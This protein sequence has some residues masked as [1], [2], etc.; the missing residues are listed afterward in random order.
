MKIFFLMLIITNILSSQEPPPADGV[1]PTCINELPSGCENI[2]LS[3]C[4]FELSQV[5]NDCKSKLPPDCSDKPLSECTNLPKEC[6]SSSNEI[7]VVTE[8]PPP[9]TETPTSLDTLELTEDGTP[10]QTPHDCV[11][12]IP[13]GCENIPLL[14]CLL[15]LTPV[16]E[17]CKV[18]MPP[19]CQDKPLTECYNPPPQCK[20]PPPSNG[21]Q[22]T[23][24]KPD[25]C[26]NESA[27]IYHPETLE[28]NVG[29]EKTTLDIPREDGGSSG[30]EIDSDGRTTIGVKPPAGKPPLTVNAPPCAQVEMKEDG[31]F[32][33]QFSTDDGVRTELNATASGDF[34]LKLKPPSGKNVEL[35]APTGSNLEVRDDGSFN[36]AFSL[37]SGLESELNISKSG[38]FEFKLKPPA[39]KPPVK[40]K[41]PAGSNMEMREDGSFK[42]YIAHENGI[43]HELDGDSDGYFD[44][45]FK[46]PKK[47]GFNFKM[48]PGSDIEIKD[49][50][51]IKEVLSKESK[52]VEFDANEDGEFEVKLELQDKDKNKTREF[53]GIDGSEVAMGEEANVTSF[54]YDYNNSLV[55]SMESDVNGTLIATISKLVP[56]KLRGSFGVVEYVQEEMVSYEMGLTYLDGGLWV[57]TYDNSNYR[58]ATTAIEASIDA[59]YTTSSNFSIEIDENLTIEFIPL[60]LSSFREITYLNKS[61]EIELLSGKCSIKIEK[62]GENFELNNLEYL[63]V[64]SN[65]IYIK[66]NLDTKESSD[67]TLNSGW[68]LISIPISALINLDTIDSEKVWSYS[69]KWIE[70]PTFIEYKSGYWVYLDSNKTINFEGF[71]YERDF[72]NLE[73]SS[74]QLI[75]S[76]VDLTNFD[77]DM[78]IYIFRD[79]KWIKNPKIIYRGEGFWIKK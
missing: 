61:K 77:K 11:H 72:S 44:F 60:E 28:A 29:E 21:T 10:I 53:V 25:E 59:N 74:W 40:L 48:P 78:T 33:Q 62:S 57:D 58:E 41:A 37:D 79:K 9:E 76:G 55:Y 27:G 8:N 65:G 63:R 16:C 67:L 12:E 5:C 51:A 4:Q 68:N 14:E 73:K 71:S 34:E 47:K 49:N 45:K 2:P 23:P 56:K 20:Q 13:T 19:D 35:K 31:S 26:T 24:P 17:E 30:F 42:N 43:E 15:E 69:S 54:S 50:G 1:A 66:D 18:I 75:G 6:G 70:N 22:I 3:E 7:V 46:H 38:E 52:R 32:D 39:N 36:N 64:D